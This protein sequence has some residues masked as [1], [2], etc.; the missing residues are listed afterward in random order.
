MGKTIGTIFNNIFT[1]FFP[2][3]STLQNWKTYDF[4]KWNLSYLTPFF[5]PENCRWWV[6][7]SATQER[8][9][10]PQRWDLIPGTNHNL[11][12]NW[13]PDNSTHWWVLKVSFIHN[14]SSCCH[15]WSEVS[16]VCHAIKPSWVIMSTDAWFQGH[17]SMMKWSS[18]CV[19]D[20][21]TDTEPRKWNFQL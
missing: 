10:T 14:K 13:R 18:K 16:S 8:H 7:L 4:R 1:N 6:S 5:L 17:Q 12:R 15:V 9:G 2:W 20:S 21:S 11:R 19:C 3:E